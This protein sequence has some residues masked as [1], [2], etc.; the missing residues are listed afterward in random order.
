MVKWGRTFDDAPIFIHLLDKQWVQYRYPSITF[1]ESREK[2]LWEGLKLVLCGDHFDGASVLYIPKH[3]GPLLTGD[4]PLIGADQKTITFMY[5]YPNYIPL[6]PK[7]IRYA[8]DSLAPFEYNVV[9]SAFGGYI[10]KDGRKMINFS[11]AILNVFNNI[12][13][14]F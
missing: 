9:F 14:S 7:A 5:S 10:P 3:K 13:L 8:K 2:E 1:W 4:T 6:S 12:L 11:I